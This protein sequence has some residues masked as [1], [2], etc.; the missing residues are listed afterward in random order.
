MEEKKN[1]KKVICIIIIILLV[2]ILLLVGAEY[3]K[4]NSDEKVSNSETFAGKKIELTSSMKKDLYEKVKNDITKDLKTPS[5]AVFQNTKDWSIRVNSNNVIEVK[6]YV[7][8]QNSFGAVLRANFEQHYILIS[9]D[10]ML[11]TYKEFNNETQFDITERAENSDIINKKISASQMKEFIDK[12]ESNK[13]NSLYNKII[14]Y[15]FNEETQELKLD[16]N[17]TSQSDGDLKYTC[18]LVST[19]IIDECICIPTV[20]TTINAYTDINGEKQ[21]IATI[22]NIDFDFMV[23]KWNAVCNT[24]IN[25]THL[26]TNF[27]EE[28]GENLTQE[29]IIKNMKVDYWNK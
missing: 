11:C 22:N 4:N 1:S 20:E 17:I 29:D 7:D 10:K 27:E 28:L 5:T 12:A 13:Y 19:S 15:D 25:A 24:G 9:N 6:S 23:K 21:K 14:D 3:I 8:S 26:I 18:Y 16:I 2:I